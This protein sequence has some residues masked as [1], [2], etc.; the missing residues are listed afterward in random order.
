MAD[1][2]AEPRVY[3]FP[4]ADHLSPSSIG[5]YLRC[6]RCF[7]Y[8]R[9]D[10]Y[11]YPLGVALPIGGAV[12]KAVEYQRQ[13]IIGNYSGMSNTLLEELD[14]CVDVAAEHFD[15]NLDVDE[16]TGTE[17]QLD[18]GSKYSTVGEA[19]DDVVRLTKIALPWLA[20][21][22][23]VRG[24]L[25]AETTLESLKWNPWPFKMEGRIDALYGTGLDGELR[26]NAGADLKTSSKQQAPDFYA[27]LQMGIYAEFLPVTWFVDVLPKTKS[28]DPRTYVADLMDEESRACVREIVMDVAKKIMDGD[29]PIRPSYFCKYV[30]GTPDFQ[31]A[32]SGFGE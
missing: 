10:K 18:L 3:T 6:P 17:V 12:H 4:H 13:A 29:F 11:P 30:H 21:L 28:P 32:V 15:S 1:A 20:K 31:L 27:A 25:A 23:S 14:E 26:I 9:I 19:K 8:S 22:D 5:D 2:V 16:E 7:Q 24:L